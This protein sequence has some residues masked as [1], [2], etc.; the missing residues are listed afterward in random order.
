ML[1][2]FSS[3]FC[4]LASYFIV[5]PLREDAAIQL[6]ARHGLRGGARPRAAQLHANGAVCGRAPGQQLAAL[7]LHCGARS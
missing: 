3:L 6:G 4:L 1:F 7:V 5:L 2:G